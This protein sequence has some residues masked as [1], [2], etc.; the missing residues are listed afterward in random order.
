M[1]YEAT[2]KVMAQ[3]YTAKGDSAKDAIFAL[4]PNNVKGKG[5]LTVDNGTEKRER[6]LSPMITSRLFNTVGLNREVA[7]KNINILFDGL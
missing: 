6:V 1:K 7:L 3:S 2:L 4:K 5:V